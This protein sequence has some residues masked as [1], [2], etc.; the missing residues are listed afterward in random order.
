MCHVDTFIVDPSVSLSKSDL[1]R[2][3]FKC[4]KDWTRAVIHQQRQQSSIGGSEAHTF[5]CGT[6]T[7]TRQFP[8]LE[9]GELIK[10]SRFLCSLN[11]F[12]WYRHFRSVQRHIQRRKCWYEEG[13]R[14]ALARVETGHVRHGAMWDTVEDFVMSESLTWTNVT[15]VCYMSTKSNLFLAEEEEG[16]RKKMLVKASFEQTRDSSRS[17][18]Q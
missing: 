13:K 18:K 12:H 15:M 3:T 6:T 4:A 11:P 5:L 17:P 7:L 1:L 14:A 9:D 16:G 8:I 2:G 10:R